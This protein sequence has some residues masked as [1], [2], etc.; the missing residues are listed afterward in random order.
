MTLAEEMYQFTQEGIK[1]LEIEQAKEDNEIWMKL[2]CEIC[3]AAHKGRD[4]IGNFS[5][6]VAIRD[7]LAKN[8][9]RVKSNGIHSYEIH[10][11]PQA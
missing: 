6:N 10:W 11:N 5:L 9:F 8:G 1:Q 4:Y 2:M 3:K 7:R